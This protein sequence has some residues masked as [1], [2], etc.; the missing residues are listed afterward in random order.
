M[1]NELINPILI[2]ASSEEEVLNKGGGRER[3]RAGRESLCET[4]SRS[5]IPHVRYALR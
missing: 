5:L 1:R 3:K 4:G 2:C